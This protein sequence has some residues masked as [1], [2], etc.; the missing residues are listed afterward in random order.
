VVGA[1]GGVLAEL[2]GSRPALLT[3]GKPQPSQD[4]TLLNVFSVRA[5][6]DLPL[7]LA[8]NQWSRFSL[9][10]YAQSAH[11]RALGSYNGKET[12]ERPDERPGRKGLDD[13][14]T[15]ALGWRSLNVID[16]D[17]AREAYLDTGIQRTSLFAEY[18]WT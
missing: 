6:R 4:T 9:H 7:R 13:G 14:Y 16:V 8:A 12:F 3:A 18:G 5:D 17:P 2:T 10:P 1:T 11:A 15:A